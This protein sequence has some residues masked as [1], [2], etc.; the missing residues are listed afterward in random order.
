MLKAID[1]PYKNHLFRS[2]LEARYAVYFDALNVE[3]EYEKEGFDLGDGLYYLPDF[4]LPEFGIYA[5]IKPTKFNYKEH[6]KCK[7]L[8]VLSQKKVIELVG[9]PN[10]NPSTV[11]EPYQNYVCSKCGFTERYDFD[12]ERI[13]CECKAKHDIVKSVVENE[14]ILLLHSDKPTYKPLYYTIH[15]DDYTN[16]KVIKRAIKKATEARFEFQ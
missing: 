16:D 7:R 13:Y 1:T 6:T 14:A 4:Y 5:E 3:W 9:L 8:A 15:M 12:G 10:V 11:I 2:R